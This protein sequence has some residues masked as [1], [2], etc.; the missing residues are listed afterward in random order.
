MV[1]DEGKVAE[2]ESPNILLANKKSKFFAL[3]KEAGQT[4]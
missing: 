1:L 4:E 2:F 3:A